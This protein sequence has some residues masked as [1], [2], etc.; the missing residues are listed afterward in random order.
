MVSEKCSNPCWLGIEAG[1]TISINDVEKKLKSH[2]GEENASISDVGENP[3][4]F[5][6]VSWRIY[7]NKSDRYESEFGSVT[8]DNNSQVKS[9]SVFLQKQQIS[10]DQLV[11][12]FGKPEIT[13][14]K[15]K[16]EDGDFPP[17]GLWKLFYPQKGLVIIVDGKYVGVMYIQQPYPA[18][19]AAVSKEQEYATKESIINWDE[20]DKYCTH[21]TLSSP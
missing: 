4:P 10:I 1:M 5:T 12:A 16:N 15:N 9:V 13:I 20:R 8:L 7:E 14:I 3:S 18:S 17:C 21:T 2:Y 19:N 6:S 11:L